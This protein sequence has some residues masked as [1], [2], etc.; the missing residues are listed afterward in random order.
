VIDRVGNQLAGV[1]AAR[2]RVGTQRS[3]PH[4]PKIQGDRVSSEREF[5]NH[6][7]TIAFCF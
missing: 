2:R 6:G 4:T 7:G 3:N 1:A 5:D